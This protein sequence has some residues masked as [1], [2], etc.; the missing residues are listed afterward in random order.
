[1]SW[2]NTI[3]LLS[4]NTGLFCLIELLSSLCRWQYIFK[5]IIWLFSRSIKKHFS[6]V[7][8][9]RD[10]Y[11]LFL[12]ISFWY[13]W[14]DLLLLIHDYLHLILLYTIHFSSPVMICFRNGSFF[15]CFN[16]KLEMVIQK[17]KPIPL[18][19]C[20]IWV[21]SFET[22]PNCFKC[23]WTVDKVN[24]SNLSSYYA[25]CFVWSSPVAIGQSSRMCCIFEIKITTAKFHWKHPLYTHHATCNF[26]FFLA[27][28]FYL[29]SI[30]KTKY[31]SSYFCHSAKQ[32]IYSKIDDRMNLAA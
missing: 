2:L 9:N 21:S 26:Y 15:S 32:T 7:P 18:K 28:H 16:R 30:K 19:T 10:H 29:Y 25:I 23:S 24:Q 3:A 6:P 13:P 1:M 14:T 12:D 17:T 20:G 27:L 11:L 4:A 8:P 5:L 22:K 31:A